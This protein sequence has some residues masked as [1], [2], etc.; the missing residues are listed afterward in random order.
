[1]K[2]SAVPVLSRAA[3]RIAANP[4]QLKVALAGSREVAR[5]LP[6]SVMMQLKIASRAPVLRP[7]AV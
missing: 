6:S 3:A 1:M 4:Q 7:V 2:G 5:A